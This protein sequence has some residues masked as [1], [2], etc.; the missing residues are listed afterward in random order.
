MD[1]LFEAFTQTETGRQ[2]Q[3]GT[4][5][6]LPISR[7]FVQLMGGDITGKSEVGKGTTFT[8]DI[9]VGIVD[10]VEM[11]RKSPARR[12]IALE[13][14]QPRYRILVVD[15]KPDNRKLLVKLLSPFGFKLQEAANGQEAF[16]IWQKWQPDLIWMDLR[17]PVMDGYKAMQY[18]KQAEAQNVASG[19]QHSE[20]EHTKVIVLSASIIDA[21][22]INAIAAG[23]DDFLHKP[24]HEHEVFDLLHKH[25]GVRFVYEETGS[26]VAGSTVAV[27]DVVTPEALAELPADVLNALHEA[28]NS[29]DIKA[30]HGIIDQIRRPH[31][32]LAEALERL[33]KVYRFDT[34]Q[35]ALDTLP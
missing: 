28:V 6:G 35:E 7:S 11:E 18:I 16:E 25:L 17:M 26:R 8:F 3:E 23:C 19:S 29:L 4:G 2:S 34:I 22:R 31:A 33:V 5:L 12:A 32:A 10:A 24:F 14:G 13:P 21:D 30:T 15:D 9:R 20:P 27:K 1:T